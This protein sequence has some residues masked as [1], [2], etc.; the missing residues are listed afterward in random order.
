MKPA[1]LPQDE[2]LRL[3]SL[4]NMRILDTPVEE[5]FERITRLAKKFFNVAISAISLID[6]DRQWFKSNPGLDVRE[7]HRDYSFCGH[8]IL[9]DGVFVVENTLA[10]ERF[11]DNPLV[12]D[13][14]YIRFY[15]GIPIHA[16]DRSRIG[17]LCLLDHQP[18][19]RDEFD[20]SVLADLAALVE[21]EFLFESP[22]NTSSG[23]RKPGTDTP[24][25]LDEV[26]GLWN[27]NGITRIL[28]EHGHRV[29]LL[30]DE[31]SLAWL[32]IDYTLAA[33]PSSE[34]VNYVQRELAGRI[35]SA[36][37]FQDT[38]GLVT[39]SQF[40]IILG[41]SGREELITRLSIIMERIL[42][43]FRHLDH[44]AT[45]HH[46]RFSCLC[47][48]PATVGIPELL[49]QLEFALPA[50]SCPLGTLN[51]NYK[52]RPETIQLL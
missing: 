37:D 42:T 5:R 33:N 52:S 25:L 12:V 4:T 17:T 44:R 38:M 46:V 40:L 32:H 14:P 27:W 22:M 11:Y 23:G 2:V 18:H 50:F 6:E 49:D 28:E 34:E 15:A 9:S 7:T 8:A 35:L 48:M 43:L 36:L 26:T 13:A 10:D 3:K 47:G 29:R 1:D 24:T 45:L 31:H 30:Q 19:S 51:L 21:R 39:G 41:E 16:S 20:F